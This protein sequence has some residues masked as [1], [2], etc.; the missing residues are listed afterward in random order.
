MEAQ[1]KHFTCWFPLDEM[2]LATIT[3][4]VRKAYIPSSHS[5]K[6]IRVTDKL[7]EQGVN[8]ASSE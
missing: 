2:K 1:P 3:T 7:I 5:T 4:T 8:C 6:Q